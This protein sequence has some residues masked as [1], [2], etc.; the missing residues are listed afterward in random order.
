MCPDAPSLLQFLIGQMP[1]AEA[2]R[3][4]EHIS[5]CRRCGKL[6]K[7]LRAKDSLLEAFQKSEGDA[8]E[9][10]YGELSDR[11][12]DSLLQLLAPK[13]AA[14][15][16]SKTGSTAAG[17]S[18]VPPPGQ[19]QATIPA[20]SLSPSQSAEVDRLSAHFEDAWKQDRRPRIEDFL[21]DS[22]GPV[23]AALLA[24]LLAME[25]GF[26]RRRGERPTAEEYHSRFPGQVALLTPAALE[27]VDSAMAGVDSF[28][29][30]APPRLCGELGRLANYR[31]LSVL[32]AGGMGIVFKAQDTR[33]NRVVA[34]KVMKPALAASASARRR[35]VREAQTAAAVEHEHIV[36]VYEVDEDRGIPFLAMPLL[37]GET[38][39]ARLQREK[40][41]PLSE[42]VAIGRAA[43]DGLAAAHEHGLVH[44]DVKPG[45]IWLEAGTGRLKLL[46]FGLARSLGDDNQLSAPGTVVG[47][48]SYMSPEQARGEELDAR[49][50]LFSLGAMLYHMSTGTLP[51]P[52]GT[53]STGNQPRAPREVNPLI[54]PEFSDLIMKLLAEDRRAR[55]SSARAVSEALASLQRPLAARPAPVAGQPRR[56]VPVAATAVLLAG[57][58][59]AGLA[60]GPAIFRFATNKGQLVIESEDPDVQL[61]VKDASHVRIIDPKANRT[62][63]LTPGEYEIELVEAPQGLRL[64]TKELRMSR[65]GR[66]IVRVWW[67]KP[68]VRPDK[69][70]PLDRLNPALIP[71]EERFSWQNDSAKSAL[72]AVLGSGRLRHWNDIPDLA[73]APDGRMLASVSY[74]GTA[75]LWDA[76]NGQPGKTLLG[77]THRVHGVAFSPDGKTLATASWDRT[78]RLW[79]VSTGELVPTIL[80]HENSVYA[81]AFGPRD[82]QLA[83]GSA[84]RTVK[85]WN[86]ATGDLERTLSGHL[87]PVWAVT[88]NKG[89]DLVAS[90]SDDSSIKL[91]EVATGKVVRNLTGHHGPVTSL[92]FNSD[93][94]SLVS[95]SRD[96]TL[97]TWNVDSGAEMLS[98]AGQAG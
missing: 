76:S 88:F 68:V 6:V 46:D 44:R 41:L 28:D 47:T 38:L 87:G 89:G 16:K 72:V 92:A 52:G 20:A 73:F 10:A 94:R 56:R 35:F 97:K 70:S 57:V 86:S 78:V 50:D 96:G 59:I 19:A 15:G 8:A 49:C 62:I 60:F 2:A 32:G 37:R 17:Q 67:E 29:F 21:A 79:N 12:L 7:T 83:S 42:I 36:A 14:A 27:A 9:E 64:S 40:S 91:W 77:H 90:A 48:P 61:V 85:L 98:L 43:A 45:N 1:E 11:R 74:D 34:L 23:R 66:E 95:G 18:T 31:I 84:D 69:T 25:L 63:D 13:A 39:S 71:L 4:Q 53:S 3:I 54:P 26:R 58:S 33:L 65:G 82:H 5:Q 30:L 51:F 81:V 55:P 24:R 93:G 80:K 22:T 75:Q